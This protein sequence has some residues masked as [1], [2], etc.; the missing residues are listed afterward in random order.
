MTMNAPISVEVKRILGKRPVARTAFQRI[1]VEILKESCQLLG[2]VVKCSGKRQPNE[3]IKG[4]YAEALVNYVSADF[5]GCF[6]TERISQGNRTTTIDE[7][8]GEDMSEAMDVDTK[9]EIVP[10]EAVQHTKV[11]QIRLYRQPRDWNAVREMDFCCGP[12]GEINLENVGKEF[13]FEEACRVCSYI[14][15]ISRQLKKKR[16]R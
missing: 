1:R 4:D 14:Q 12:N 11:I 13:G 15:G 10:Q 5:G 16:L 3:P 7:N 9:E 8:G 6:P 2:L